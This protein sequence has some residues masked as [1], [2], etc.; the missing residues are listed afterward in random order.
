MQDHSGLEERPQAAL[1]GDLRP[2]ADLGGGI[3]GVAIAIREIGWNLWD[4]F[5][6]L[7]FHYM[8]GYSHIIFPSIFTLEKAINPSQMGI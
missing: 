3:T 5:L 6:A 8:V 7:P 4:P 1:P 2:Q